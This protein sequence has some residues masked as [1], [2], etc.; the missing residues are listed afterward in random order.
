MSLKRDPPK[1]GCGTPNP[2]SMSIKWSL[3]KRKKRHGH[4]QNIK[5]LLSLP[6]EVGEVR[7]TANRGRGHSQV[8]MAD[9]TV[10]G[11]FRRF[12]SILRILRRALCR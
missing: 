3:R 4:R 11:R 6:G 10:V 7:V 1:V 12:R 2:A 9:R 5:F 8:S